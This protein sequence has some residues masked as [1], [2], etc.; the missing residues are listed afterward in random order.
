MYAYTPIYSPCT[1]R[2][3]VSIPCELVST[4]GSV[5]GRLTVALQVTAVCIV[6]SGLMNSCWTVEAVAVKVFMMG[7]PLLVD[8]SD[9]MSTTT[10]TSTAGSRVI[11]QVR[12][13]DVPAMREEGGVLKDISG[14][15]T[16]QVMMMK[17]KIIKS[18]RY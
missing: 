14:V 16:A 18:M 2:F 3:T 6:L 11:V 1:V 13:R 10:L 8:I 12:L 17:L 9:T 4:K 5:D 7:S 15:G